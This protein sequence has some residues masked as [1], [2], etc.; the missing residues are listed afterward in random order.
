MNHWKHCCGHSFF[1]NINNIRDGARI[2]FLVLVLSLWLIV[3]RKPTRCILPLAVAESENKQVNQSTEN[4][5]NYYNNW[6][7][8]QWGGW[9]NRS[10]ARYKSIMPNVKAP[11]ITLISALPC[12]LSLS[13]SFV[14]PHSEKHIHIYC[15]VSAIQTLSDTPASFTHN[16][17]SSAEGGNKN[18][19]SRAPQKN[20]RNDIRV[21]WSPAS[22][23]LHQRDE[24]ETLFPKSFL[25]NHLEHLQLKTDL[26]LQT[27]DSWQ[28]LHFPLYFWS[29][30]GVWEG[31]HTARWP[32][33]ETEATCRS[34]S[35]LRSC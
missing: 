30:H 28:G 18:V 19:F 21:N 16:R 4:N 20:R 11:L 34:A 14:S 26:C 1:R 35:A 29:Q 2:D 24:N 13:A 32:S 10:W 12:S 8:G 3:A 33:K 31:A 25:H 17:E 15:S 22:I 7:A 6:N 5:N 23:Y 27:L 9:S